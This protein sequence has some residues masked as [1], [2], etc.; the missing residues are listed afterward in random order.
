MIPAGGSLEI[1]SIDGPGIIRHIWLA[2]YDLPDAMRAV[3]I[4]AYWDGQEHPSIEAPLGDFFGFAH[5][6]TPPYASAV[7]SVGE[8]R[9]LNIWLP[10]P[11]RK[12]ARW[13]LTND[14]DIAVPVFF[15]M[16][17]TVGDALEGEVGY[18]HAHF[19]RECL[20]REGVDY[21]ILP[22]REG[23]GRYLG[24]VIGVRPTS[25]AWWGEGEVRI[26]LDGD[27]DQPTIVGTGAEDYACLSWGLQQNTFPFHGANLVSKGR[28]D[29]GPV[30]MYRWHL[31]DPVYWAESIRVT[32]QQI[33]IDLRGPA[34][35]DSLSGYLACLRDRRDDWCSCAF[36]YESVPSAP[37]PTPASFE[38]RMEALELTAHRHRLPFQP[39]FHPQPEL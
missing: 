4:R 28:T 12:H 1:A 29:T 15:Q 8:K 35:P 19:R 38:V 37:L 11:F 3:V 20:T 21:E 33:G 10:M 5:G 14:L 13:T 16:D 32:I 2:T 22:L 24:A 30:S 36:W 27:V 34:V 7:H 9:A 25:S 23:V 26:F 39:G 6:H 18:L 31:P 17:F